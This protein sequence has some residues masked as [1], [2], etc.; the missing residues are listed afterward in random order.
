MLPSAE[1]C[2]KIG[3]LKHLQEEWIYQAEEGKWQVSHVLSLKTQ[4]PFALPSKNWSPNIC[5]QALSEANWVSHCSSVSITPLKN[6]PWYALQED[7]RGLVCCCIKQNPLFSPVQGIL[8][9]SK[10]HAN[11][12]PRTRLWCSRGASQPH[13]QPPLSIAR[14][15]PLPSTHARRGRVWCLCWMEQRHIFPCCTLQKAEW[16]K[17]C[18]RKRK[19]LGSNQ[20]QQSQDP[21]RT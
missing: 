14:Q 16:K 7:Q 9:D 2:Q 19:S 6:R 15:V 13:R 8:A 12:R 3:R 11:F 17:N 10:V 21:K 18:T 20:F 1:Y 5:P 4:P